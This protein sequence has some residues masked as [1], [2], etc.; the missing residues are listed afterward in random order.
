MNASIIICTRNRADSLAKTLA[1]LER[2]AIPP[3]LHPEILVVDNGSTA[4]TAKVVRQHPAAR[5]SIRGLSEP[6]PGQ[7]RARNAGLAASSAELILC[8]DD[9][10]VPAMDW[11]KL[12]TAPLAQGKCEGVAGKVKLA[13]E[14][15]R[16]WMIGMHVGWLAAYNGHPQQLIGANMAFHR[17]VLEKVPKFDVELGPGAL[18]Y[19]DET[20][21]SWQML[22]AGFGLKYIPEAFVVHYPEPSRLLRSSWLSAGRKHG[23]SHAYLLHHWQHHTI[24][25]PALRR[26]YV[27]AKLRLRRLVQPPPPLNGEGIAPWEMS[28]V[29]EIEKCRQYLKE[30]QRPRN[31]SKRGLRKLCH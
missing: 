12:M 25:L 3:G 20:L 2:L 17:S 21:F 6:V 19:I 8:T 27:A 1:A 15:R 22:E 29:A 23:A 18:G 26:C 4:H 31:Y 10:V 28:Y 7:A 13:E 30:R 24:P 16:P 9:D 11:L 5:I 14:L